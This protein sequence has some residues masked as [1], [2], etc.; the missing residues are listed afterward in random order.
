MSYRSKHI[1]ACCAVFSLVLLPA[2]SARG[3]G[4]FFVGL[5]HGLGDLNLDHNFTTHEVDQL[6]ASLGLTLPLTDGKYFLSYRASASFHGVTDVIYGSNPSPDD[7]RY[8]RNLDQYIGG[9]NGFA[10]GTRIDLSNSVYL[11]PMLGVGVF[12]HVIYGNRGEG[13][14][15]G[16]YQTDLSVLAMREFGGYDLGVWLSLGYIPV[17]GYGDRMDSGSLTFGV[18]LS[19]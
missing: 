12:V 17:G 19:L 14:A 1:L 11:E 15:F 7:E 5:N 3:G 13:I 9:F 6:G 18:A 2:T 8:Y 10:I 16:S 4:T